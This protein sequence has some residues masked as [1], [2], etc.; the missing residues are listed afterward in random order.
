MTGAARLP[1]ANWDAVTEAFLHDPPDKVLRLQDHLERAERYLLA[2]GVPATVGHGRRDD[3]VAA[4]A[5]RLPMPWGSD[6]RGGWDDISVAPENG[7]LRV[8]HPLSGAARE[9][10]VPGIDT[11]AVADAVAEVAGDSGGRTRFL[12]LWRRLPEQLARNVHPAYRWLPADSRQPDH[13][14]WH[15]A[16]VTAAAAACDWNP[17]FLSFHLGPV[18]GFIAA[19][20][21][22]RDLWSGSYLLSHLVWEAMTPVIEHLG[23]QCILYPYL[24]GTPRMDH[25]LRRNHVLDLPEDETALLS[26]VYPNRFLALVPGAS[27]REFAEACRE[28]CLQAWREL[29]ESVRAWM[30]E[31]LGEGWDDG[32]SEQID[33]WFERVTV[34]LPWRIG[35]DSVDERLAALRRLRGLPEIPESLAAVRELARAIPEPDRPGYDQ[36]QVG[37]WQILF[38][39]VGRLLEARRT[40]RHAPRAADPTD[41][42]RKCSL[43]G[44]L[45]VM[46]PRGVPDSEVTSWWEK[47]REKLRHGGF[48]LRAREALCAV[49]LVKRFAPVTLADELDVDV[50]TTRIDDTATVAAAEWLARAEIDPEEIRRNHEQWSGHWLHWT[51]PDQEVADGEDP[52]P[53]EVWERIQKARREFGRP[54]AY[55]AVLAGDGD[56]L[57]RWLRGELG[58]T[59]RQVLHPVLVRYFEQVDDPRVAHALEARRYVSPALH[60]AVSEALTSFAVDAARVL[61]AEHRGQLVYAG[62]DDV[63]ALL[64]LEH[65]LVTAHG[66]R[67][68]YQ[69]RGAAAAR[70]LP[71][72]GPQAGFSAGLVAFHYKDDLRAALEA[73][74]RAEQLAKERGRD[75]LA[76]GVRRRSGEHTVSVTPWESI[77][78]LDRVRKAFAA[79]ASDRFVYTLRREAQALEGT[80][81]EATGAE[82]ERLLQRAERWGPESGRDVLDLWAGWRE[83]GRWTSDF[84]ILLQTLAFLARGR[85]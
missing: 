68:A 63:L 85:D 78:R 71:A 73:A 83:D 30:L 70:E 66:I 52:C 36:T 67:E 43:L 49:S 22:L 35:D 13:T 75:L 46:G 79:G 1:A 9:L 65:A 44:S 8:V 7:R 61:V 72:M 38:D 54:P 17:A 57:G 81:G 77:P 41:T 26:P 59:V 6:R 55:L 2:A 74:R 39:H 12:R 23:P 62:G 33:S 60:A 20:R 10:A 50:R 14:I 31:K 84:A 5:E 3:A 76:L 25:W 53:G 29:A 80:R 11:T 37:R 15:H 51:T 28:R 4:Q 21:T 42:R 82:L 69:G 18:Q 34:V 64:P 56:H 27:A 19:A 45:E 40:T 48:R 32:W 16:D 58:P 47:H 24:R